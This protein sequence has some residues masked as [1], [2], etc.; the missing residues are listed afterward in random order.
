LLSRLIENLKRGERAEFTVIAEN[1]NTENDEESFK[2]NIL[3]GL[4]PGYDKTKNLYVTC[5]LRSLVKVEDWYKDGTTMVKTIRSGGKGRSAYADST[6]KLRMK[7]EVNDQEIY[8][9]YP[10]I[11]S[12]DNLRFMTPAER[13]EF[14]KDPTLLTLRIDDY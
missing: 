2:D 6:I 13:D 12:T 1:F 4:I 9:N 5:E 3:P 8:S 10:T 7:V 11:E 14:L